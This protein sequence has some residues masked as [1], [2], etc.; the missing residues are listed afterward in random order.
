MRLAMLLIV[1]GMPLAGFA[2]SDLPTFSQGSNVTV[3]ATLRIASACLVVSP[4]A[5]D[6]GTLGLTQPGMSAAHTASPPG[7]ATVTVRNCSAQAET[8]MVKGGPASG[9]GVTWTHAPGADV[10]VGPNLFVQGVRDLSRNDRRL[11]ATDQPLKTLAAGASESVMLTLVPPCSGS[12]GAGQ[13][14]TV[15][16]TFTATLAESG[17]R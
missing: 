3:T 10:C 16:Y 4:T 12:A 13:T 2:L 1:L 5:V 11:T 6:L 8:I 17:P 9:P 15:P 7:T 14:I